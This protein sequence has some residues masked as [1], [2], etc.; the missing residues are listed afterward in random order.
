[1]PQFRFFIPLSA[2]W[3][4]QEM[5]DF[6][7]PA[8]QVVFILNERQAQDQEL[9]GKCQRLRDQGFYFA[10]HGGAA[11]L[12]S[13]P[14]ASDIAMFNAKA[15]KDALPDS[16]WP[17]IAQSEAKLFAAAIDSLEL[18]D[19]CAEKSFAFHTFAS[20]EGFRNSKN[21]LKG[22]SRVTLMKLL[23]MVTQDADTHDLELTLRKEPKLSFDLL[24]LVNSA[25]MGLRTKVSSF[26][27]ALTILGRRQ[28]QRWL[29][30][31]L[32]VQQKQTGSGP[33]ILMQRAAMRGRLMELL[34][35]GIGGTPTQE[36][37]EQAFMVGVFS[38]LDILMDD[39]LANILEPLHLADHI[40]AALLRHEGTLGEMLR[41]VELTE[42]FDFSVAAQWLGTLNIDPDFFSLAQARALNWTHLLNV[43]D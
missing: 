15:A 39:S 20:L 26:G 6:A 43:S 1:M 13:R 30:L 11:P 7:F 42:N 5:P 10:L 35:E 25:S 4:N 3:L 34:T 36:F 17:N 31:L 2:E 18:F 41:L 12:P 40:E 21:K 9:L 14:E 33:S 27:H 8:N 38:Q 19:W 32:F 37:Q 23:S 22:A 24:R 16:S 29:Q 28:L